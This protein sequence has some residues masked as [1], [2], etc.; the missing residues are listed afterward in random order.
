MTKKRIK[1]MHPNHATEYRNHIWFHNSLG[2]R[3]RSSQNAMRTIA[4][5]PSC[6]HETK[7]LA[8]RIG[9][10]MDELAT[11]MVNRVDPAFIELYRL[12]K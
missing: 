2:G 5:S 10:L 12:G 8:H 7:E 9:L 6:D 3:L 4:S 1:G 11:K